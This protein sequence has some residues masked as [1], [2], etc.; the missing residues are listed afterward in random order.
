[1]PLEQGKMYHFGTHNVTVDIDENNN[2][3]DIDLEWNKW[4]KIQLAISDAIKKALEANQVD[5]FDRINKIYWEKICKIIEN[6]K[7]KQ[8]A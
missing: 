1:M 3:V 2:V 8:A 4:Y 6:E 7:T 5:I